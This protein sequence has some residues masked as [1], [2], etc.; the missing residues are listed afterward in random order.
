MSTERQRQQPASGAFLGAVLKLQ[1][2][3]F[4]SLFQ[5]CLEYDEGHLCFYQAT[6][7]IVMFFPNYF[8]KSYLETIIRKLWFGTEHLLSSA[9]AGRELWRR[10]HS[11][12][13]NSRPD[14]RPCAASH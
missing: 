10:A 8:F 7:V 12:L 4:V 14:S 3:A 6:Q 5:I 11:Q 9:S 1:S 13:K 2:V